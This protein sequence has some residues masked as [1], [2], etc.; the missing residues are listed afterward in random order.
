MPRRKRPVGVFEPTKG[1]HKGCFCTPCAL[2]R[3][4]ARIERLEQRQK[5][6]EAQIARDRSAQ[7]AGYP[8][9]D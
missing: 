6:L 1:H 5:D 2:R 4:V 3:N 8:G 7:F 9:Y